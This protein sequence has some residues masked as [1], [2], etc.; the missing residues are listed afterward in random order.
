MASVDSHLA[1]L[2]LS[3]S[4]LLLSARNRIKQHSSP[5]DPATAKKAGRGEIEIDLSAGDHDGRDDW[6]RR[7]DDGS[8]QTV[9]RSSRHTRR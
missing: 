1:V 3:Y 2:L 8:G 4:S 9:S 6:K 5:T 7:R